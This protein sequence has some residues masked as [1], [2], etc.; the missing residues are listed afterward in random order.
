MKQLFTFMMLLSLALQREPLYAQAS[1]GGGAYVDNSTITSSVLSNNQAT[2]A[3]TGV[4]ATGSSQLVNNTVADNRQLKLFTQ[5]VGDIYEGGVVFYVNPEDRR[6]LVAS[7][8]EAPD[9][10]KYKTWGE[11]GQEV[12]GAS[13]TEDGKENTAKII[14]MQTIT[15]A[16]DAKANNTMAQI[17]FTLPPDTIRRAAHWCAEASNKSV[18]GWFLPSRE[19]LKQ[20]YV[21]KD[22][23]NPVLSAKG[24]TVLGN[25]YYWSSTQANAHEAWYVFFDNGET[26]TSLKSNV[27][28]V[29]AIREFSY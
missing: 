19:Q 5:Q 9:S 26:N 3:G 21:A 22:A 11:N 18:S 17:D 8:T 7:L 27:A 2:G 15:P 29:R 12:D 23:I 16:I 14:A 24:A 13:N 20:L 6:G 28:N 1:Q 4:Y 25:G 10:L